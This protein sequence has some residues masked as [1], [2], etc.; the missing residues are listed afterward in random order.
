MVRSQYRPPNRRRN[1]NLF[2]W[3]LIGGA[4]VAAYLFGPNKQPGQGLI[5]APDHIYYRRCADAR[6]AGAAPIYR[7]QP[8]YREELDADSD[9]IACEHYRGD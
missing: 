7:G 9:G 6:A 5:S 8:G 1:W 4:A 2:P 3:I